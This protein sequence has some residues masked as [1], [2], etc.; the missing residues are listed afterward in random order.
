MLYEH[1]AHHVALIESLSNKQN[2]A[3]LSIEKL[4]ASDIKLTLYCPWVHSKDFEIFMPPLMSRASQPTT[5][6]CF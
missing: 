4:K 3:I 5:L 1:E 6:I 2:L